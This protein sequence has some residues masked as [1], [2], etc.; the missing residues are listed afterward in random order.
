MNCYLIESGAS[1]DDTPYCVRALAW[2]LAKPE[3]FKMMYIPSLQQLEGSY[4]TSAIG[5]QLGHDSKNLGLIKYAKQ[6]IHVITD[7][8]MDKVE[9]PVRL[10]ACYCDDKS[11]ARMEELLNIQDILVFPWV[12]EHD[13]NEWKKKY[14]PQRILLDS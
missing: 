4:F 6:E 12:P 11:L 3:Q 13:V 9:D 7:D 10:F 5:L 8:I 1:D 2:L 14:N